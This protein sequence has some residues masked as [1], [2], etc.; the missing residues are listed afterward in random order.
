MI[1]LGEL[2]HDV[3]VFRCRLPRIAEDS[4]AESGL[5]AANC[6]NKA[7][8]VLPICTRAWHP[9]NQDCTLPT[10]GIT[11]S[12][13][14]LSHTNISIIGCPK[15]VLCLVNGPMCHWKHDF[16]IRT[17]EVLRYGTRSL[18]HSRPVSWVG[19]QQSDGTTWMPT[20]VL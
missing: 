7:A 16:Y 12:L 5:S 8:A 2:F 10:Y 14:R 1:L 4:W 15:S 17:N 6:N 3:I 18:I 9:N 20:Q 13:K 19:G 11:P